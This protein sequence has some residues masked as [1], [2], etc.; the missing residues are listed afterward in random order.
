MSDPDKT[1]DPRTDFEAF[2]AMEVEPKLLDFVATRESMRSRIVLGRRLKFAAITLV[3]VGIGLAFVGGIAANGE[4]VK[5]IG[6]GALGVGLLARHLVKKYYK[7]DENSLTTSV[8]TFAVRPLAPAFGL[9]LDRN[10][11]NQADNRFDPILPRYTDWHVDDAIRGEIDSKGVTFRD[12]ELS[13]RSRRRMRTV[14]EGII[15][16]IRH[17]TRTDGDI[18]VLPDDS[19]INEFFSGIADTYQ[20]VVFPSDPEFERTFT[21]RARNQRAALDFLSDDVRDALKH[22]HGRYQSRRTG[23]IITPGCVRFSINNSANMGE[24]GDSLDV[25]DFRTLVRQM[26]EEF[27]ELQSLVKTLSPLFA[28]TRDASAEPDRGR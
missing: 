10:D 8:R 11:S 2:F 9:F 12:L 3:V 21:V 13:V 19:A 20:P 26:M 17:S 28:K 18:L 7:N 5:A 16:E 25:Q 22:V 1:P 27:T 15:G 6:F 24:L 23:F 14:F 4:T